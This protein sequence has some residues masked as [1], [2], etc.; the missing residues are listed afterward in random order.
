MTRLLVLLWLLQSGLGCTL[1]PGYTLNH[2][3]KHYKID[4]KRGFDAAVS[5]C[6]AENANLVMPKTK[7]EFDFFKT[8]ESIPNT[9]NVTIRV[10]DIE[11]SCS[12]SRGANLGRS[13]A[14]NIRLVVYQ[15]RV[16]L[17]VP[18]DGWKSLST[19]DVHQSR[20]S[21]RG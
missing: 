6:Q 20:R 21:C 19:L 12:C 9:V 11:F 18:M 1:P 3:R 17:G 5:F 13:C 10:Y 16:Q 14:Q 15:R 2:G 8:V 7:E 4:A